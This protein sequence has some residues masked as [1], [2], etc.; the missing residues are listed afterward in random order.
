MKICL[1]MY[2][3]IGKKLE[4][5]L[6]KNATLISWY[7]EASLKFTPQFKISLG[8]FINTLDWIRL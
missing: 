1:K 4:K 5:L 3:R 6:Q 2:L 8:M 7:M